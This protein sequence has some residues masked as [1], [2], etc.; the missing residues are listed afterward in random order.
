MRE[1]LVCGTRFE[2]GVCPNCHPPADRQQANELNTLIKVGLGVL[3]AAVALVT[4][5]VRGL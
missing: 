2:E 1:C 3:V 4:I 5:A